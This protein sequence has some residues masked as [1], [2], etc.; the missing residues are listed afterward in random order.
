MCIDMYTNLYTIMYTYMYID[1]Y[2]VNVLTVH[3]SPIVCH[4]LYRALSSRHNLVSRTSSHIIQQGSV[5]V[6]QQYFVLCTDDA[7]M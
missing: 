1:M 2:T 4:S 6:L 7:L 5:D 3:L